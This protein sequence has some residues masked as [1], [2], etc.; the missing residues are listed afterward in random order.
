MSLKSFGILVDDLKE[1]NKFIGPPLK[2][3]FKE[4]YNFDEEK[5]QLGLV[6]YR[7]Y[8][9]DKGIY[10]NKLYDGIPELLEVLKKNK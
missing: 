8:F 9:A 5:A 10:E 6:K 1:L 2:D 7:E 4:Y 3:S